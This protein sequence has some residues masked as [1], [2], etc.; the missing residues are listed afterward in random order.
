MNP[1]TT[2]TAPST[3]IA[4]SDS[5]NWIGAFHASDLLKAY[6]LGE[7]IDGSNGGNATSR[8]TDARHL[9]LDKAHA[10]FWGTG[11]G[12]TSD[13]E[14]ADRVM[15]TAVFY[16]GEAVKAAPDPAAALRALHVALGMT[17]TEG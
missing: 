15:S 17:T 16:M 1:P 7:A 9:T 4:Q 10:D 13:A 12:R 8:L 2:S 5:P 6:D 11:H 14:Y 3:P